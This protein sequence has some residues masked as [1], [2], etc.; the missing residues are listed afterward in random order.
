MA[1]AQ[2][3]RTSRR[4]ASRPLPGWIWLLSGLMIGLFVAFVVWLGVLP[5]R[6]P[7]TAAPA[8][9]AAAPTAEPPS[10]P[11]F[12]FYTLLPEMEVVV[13]ESR[14]LPPPA[15]RPS[16]EPRPEGAEA[17]ASAP[18]PPVEQPGHYLL[19]V[20]SFRRAEEA[21]RLRASLALLGIVSTVQTVTIDG[22]ETW[23]RVRIGPYRDTGQ[24]NSVRQRLHDNGIESV[25]LN[26]RP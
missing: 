23:H 9:A 8:P 26:V 21:D 18:P 15:P 13:P 19:Q 5:L 16:T 24:L 1:R 22:D 25:V 10:R 17:T 12:D 14:P 2:A 4:P 11:R 20:G 6:D 3:R 7:P